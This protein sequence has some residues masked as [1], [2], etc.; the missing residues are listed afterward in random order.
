[1]AHKVSA[2]SSARQKGNVIGKRRG[3]KV[4][5]GEFVNAGSILVRQLGTKYLPG[6]G[7]A[8][9]RDFTIFAMVSGKVHFT[10]G[11]KKKRGRTV[12]N[13]ISQ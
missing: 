11:T 10:K 7:T 13:V 12:V 9:G 1:M 3:V 6:V 2:A 8:L 4:S 5:E